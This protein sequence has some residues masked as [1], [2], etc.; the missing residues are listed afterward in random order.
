MSELGDP[1]INRLRDTLARYS[2][3]RHAEGAADQRVNN[4]SRWTLRT[5]EAEANAREQQ[6]HRLK[7]EIDVDLLDVERRLRFYQEA[8]EHL[9]ETP[10]GV[11][12][13][14][15]LAAASLDATALATIAGVKTD[16]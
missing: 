1:A 15:I 3:A 5:R 9:A 2:V 10:T 16:A 12:A 8:L 13:R 6:A 7:Q 14:T 11:Y 4:A